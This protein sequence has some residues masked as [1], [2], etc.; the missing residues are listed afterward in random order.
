MDTIWS[1]NLQTHPGPIY[2]ALEAAIRAGVADGDLAVGT[3]LPPVRD[4]AWQLKVTPGTVARAYKALVDGG[5]LSSAVGRG[6]FVAGEARARATPFLAEPLPD[7]VVNLRSSL[8]PDVGQS[9]MF[10]AAFGQIAQDATADYLGYPKLIDDIVLRR[11]MADWAGPECHGPMAVEDVILC[12]GAIQA[13]SLTLMALLRGPAPVI[14]TEELAFPAFRH[15]AGL[16]RATIR[17]VPQDA[18]GIVPDALDRIARDTGAQ[19]LCTSAEVHNPT[20]CRTSPDRREAIARVARHRGLQIIDD[21]TYGMGE[22]AAGYRR[23][24]P[25][26]S[27]VLVSVAKSLSPDLRLGAVIAPP[28]QGAVVRGVA[29]QQFQGLSRPLLDLATHV[30]SSGQAVQIRDAV[31]GVID[32]RVAIARDI[33]APFGPQI[34]DG[35]PFLWLHMPR[36]WRSSAFLR[37]GDGAG[38]RFKAADEFCLVDGWAPNAVRLALVSEPSEAKYT[39]ALHKLAGLLA[40]PM[41]AM[42]V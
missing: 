19:V 10:H 2:K 36:G 3:R 22:G 15:A 13:M 18:D 39:A 4:L 37:A 7:G 30:F 27:W 34:R 28:G 23:I 24:A 32:R 33:L 41:Q 29:Q 8:V 31:R 14:L 38:I 35:V 5:I 1:P 20:T 42:E 9:A 6:T 26:R 16:L 25:D 12:F 40:A 21:D 11:C 17:G